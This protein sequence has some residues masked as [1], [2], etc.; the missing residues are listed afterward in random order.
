MKLAK[1]RVYRTNKDSLCSLAC[2]KK[3]SH[4]QQLID[5]MPT[6]SVDGVSSAAGKRA[7]DARY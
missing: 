6:S 3:M 4:F 1:S 7:T 5:L 2:E